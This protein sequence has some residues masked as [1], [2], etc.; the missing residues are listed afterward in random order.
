MDVLLLLLHFTHICQILSLKI[1][2]LQTFMFNKYEYITYIDAILRI[3]K[4]P[5]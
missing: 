5:L 3:I 1:Q 4:V 2:I